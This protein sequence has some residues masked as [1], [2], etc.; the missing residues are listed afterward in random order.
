MSMRI[1]SQSGVFRPFPMDDSQPSVRQDICTEGCDEGNTPRI[2]SKMILTRF[3][4]RQ[5]A[6]FTRPRHEHVSFLHGMSTG[7]WDANV[8]ERVSL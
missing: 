2:H 5:D 7:F 6:C 4:D 3:E 1:L 8:T